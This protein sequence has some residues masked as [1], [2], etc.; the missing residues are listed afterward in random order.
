MVPALARRAEGTSRYADFRLCLAAIVAVPGVFRTPVFFVPFLAPGDS[1]LFFEAAASARVCL[2]FNL[3][4]L[5]PLV[6]FPV[7]ARGTTN[8]SDHHSRRVARDSS[9]LGY[10][11]GGYSF[12]KKLPTKRRF[13]Y[14]SMCNKAQ[15]R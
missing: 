11:I 15:R 4:F 1:R 5:P 14:H 3:F 7:V 9:N 10:L 6:L 8:S 2:L 13:F 12:N